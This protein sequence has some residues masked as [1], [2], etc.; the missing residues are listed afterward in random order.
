MSFRYLDNAATTPVRREVLEAMTPYLTS[1]FGNPSS[2]H[3]VGE[4]AAR[5][6]AD[7][8]ARVAAVLGMRP[9]DV[10]FTSGATEAN[11]LAI[12]GVSIAAQQRRGARHIVTTAIEHESVLASVDYLVRIHGFEASILPVDRVGRVDPDAVA[13][14]VRA[15]T[16]SAS[17]GYANNEIGTIQDV[18][19]IAAALAGRVPLH[20]DAVQAAGWLPLSDTGADALSIAG[21]KIG[22]PKGIGA[23]GIRSRIPLEPVIH[24]GGQERERRSGTENVAGA[25]G[26]ARAVELSE[27]DRVDAAA[28]VSAMR[29]E[30]IAGV[31]DRVP[32]ARLTGDP[33]HRLPGT[34]SF[35]F[36]GV[37]GETVLLEL[38]RRG[39][40]TS[41]GSACAA[42]SDEASHV[43]L[44]L[45][46]D[47]DEARTAVRITLG[48]SAEGS[49]E[50]I[51]EAV[52]A[53]V[54]A[55]VSGV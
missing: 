50:P 36:A 20:L 17:I 2:H 5:A 46:V 16:A 4:H 24:G 55:V 35:T 52:E 14:A 31:L 30:L 28:R 53:A 18:A 26:L 43:L 8:R 32:T 45:G 6:L 51:V 19:G 38:E 39:I 25:V 47:A 41:S 12:K 7:A 13:A 42:G 33:T 48:H 44:A 40:I 29:D 54:T 22:A 1:H 15:D 3:S 37:G 49:V 11:N 27:A 23:L 9:S 21:H 10:I 34:A